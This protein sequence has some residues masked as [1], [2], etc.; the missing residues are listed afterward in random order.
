VPTPRPLGQQALAFSASVKNLRFFFKRQDTP[1]T[2]E[3]ASAMI[4]LFYP[5]ELDKYET[6]HKKT[7]FA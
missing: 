5:T 1:Q 3:G 2:W 4:S 7:Q 6:H